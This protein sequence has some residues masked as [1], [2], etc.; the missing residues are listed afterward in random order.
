[1][2]QKRQRGKKTVKPHTITKAVTYIRLLEANPGKYVD[3]FCAIEQPDPFHPPIFPTPL[4]ERWHRVTIQQAA[5]IAQSWRTN[6]E[7]AYQDYLDELEEY[8]E[9]ETEGTLDEQAK[10]P[11]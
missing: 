10:E 5:G 11:E 6:R 1:M 2:K 8:R 9:Q 3:V 7:Q 4:S